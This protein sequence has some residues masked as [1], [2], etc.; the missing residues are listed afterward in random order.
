M[1]LDLI[2]DSIKQKSDEIISV[3]NESSST[4]LNKK[5]IASFLEEAK[6]ESKRG[7][8]ESMLHINIDDSGIF[9]SMTASVINKPL[10]KNFTDL[11]K[12]I[13]ETSISFNKVNV[14]Y[15]IICLL[16]TS[17]SPRD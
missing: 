8:L 2:K 3:Y 11:I 6:N 16:Y 4:E 9:P 15:S 12:L 13:N 1:L 10:V 17:P 7:A 14:S 5:I